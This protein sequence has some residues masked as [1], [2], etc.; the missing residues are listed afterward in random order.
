MRTIWDKMDKADW[1]T[2]PEAPFPYVAPEEFSPEVEALLKALDVPVEILD[3][4][5]GAKLH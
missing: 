2:D 1:R 4:D 5:Y 3:F